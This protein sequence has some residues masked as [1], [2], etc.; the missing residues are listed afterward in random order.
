MDPFLNSASLVPQQFSYMV[1][2]LT[3]LSSLVMAGNILSSQKPPSVRKIY[4]ERNMTELIGDDHKRVR[5]ALVSFLKPEMLKQY[6]GKMDEDV[7]P[8]MKTLTFNIMS[9]LIFGIEQGERRNTPVELLQHMMKG[10]VSLPIN[11]PF[12]R[13]NRSL[14][15][16]TRVRTLIKDLISERR[17][18]LEQRI[19]VPNKD[20]ISCLLSIRNNDPS[21]LMSDEE[22]I[23]NV[24]GVM[25]AG[26]DKSSVL[27]TFLVK[28]LV[29]DQSVYVKIILEQEEI[30]KTKTSDQEL[31]T[32]DDLAKMKYTWREAMETLRMNP[33]LSGSFRDDL[34]KMKYNI[35]KRWQVIYAAC[36]TH[37][38]EQIFPDPSK[39][40]YAASNTF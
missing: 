34:A 32:W 33:P 30:S 9:S 28:L 15:A 7:M 39:V 2:V 16:S 3:S 24:I 40:I 13:F 11:L 10:L 20:L 36:M 8:L 27:I 6:V 18:A 14:K 1:R 31:L 23:D 5:A 12:A 37:M 19:A 38:D 25:I 17:A 4:G 26:H 22:I 21:I 35:P 29:T